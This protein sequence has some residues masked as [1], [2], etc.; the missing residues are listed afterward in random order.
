[1]LNQKLKLTKT[2]AQKKILSE[3]TDTLHELS[4]V[5]EILLFNLF[6]LSK[7]IG[8]LKEYCFE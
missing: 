4:D 2:F 6:I 1:M 3:W 5:L 8:P 7:S